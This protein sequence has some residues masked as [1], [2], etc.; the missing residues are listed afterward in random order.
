MNIRII[1]FLRKLAFARHPSAYLL[2]AQLISLVLYA[3]FDD[4]PR[5]RALLGAFG[6]LL[7]VLVVW[8]VNHSPS[9]NWIAWVL[10]AM[11][12]VLSLSSWLSGD[13]SLLV[14]AALF[15]AVL[16][17][18]AAGSLIAYMMGDYRVTVPIE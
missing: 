2:L 17:F 16:Y 18:Y 5:G 13:P 3:V 15:E 8:V 9:V 12:V 1:N 6:V 4:A 14:W 11:S 7:L 10:A